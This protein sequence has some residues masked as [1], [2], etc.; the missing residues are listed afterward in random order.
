VARVGIDSIFEM[1]LSETGSRVNTP[2][3]LLYQDILR[4]SL[5]LKEYHPENEGKFR[6]REL[7]RWLIQNH[8]RYIDEYKGSHKNVSARI[9]ARLD[10]IKAKVDDLIKLKLVEDIGTAPQSKG[11]GEVDIFR[12][13]SIGYFFAWI[14]ESF[15]PTKREIANEEIF[16][17]LVNSIVK[18]E[19]GATSST[20]FF[21]NFYKKCKER[22]RFGDI[23]DFF[24]EPLL[25]GLSGLTARNY[26]DYISQTENMHM[27]VAGYFLGLADETIEELDPDVGKLALYQIKLNYERLMKDKARNP[28]GYEKLRFDCRNLHDAIVV[29]AH[30]EKCDYY[31]PVAIRYLDYAKQVKKAASST[32]V[33]ANNTCPHCRT[34][35]SMVIYPFM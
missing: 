31:I 6:V 30:C 17:L 35:D 16:K 32:I 7:A 13:T 3:A 27:D 22:G 15:K 33:L 8:S 11:S 21:S 5:N 28:S 12:Y 25:L 23:V 18:V 34:S 1:E 4:Y 9:E 19:P 24:R 2:N 10:T 29:E 14:A 26:F 20:I